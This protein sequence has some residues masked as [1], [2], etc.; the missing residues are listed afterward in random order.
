MK[1]F[2]V[3]LVALFLSITAFSQEYKNSI[4]VKLGY[5]MS[6]DY[7]HNLSESNFINT[8]TSFLFWGAFGLRAYGFYNWNFPIRSVDGLSWYVGPGAYVGFFMNSQYLGFDG[9]INA[10]IGLEYKLRNI[11]LA[12]SFDWAPGLRIT[13]YLPHYVG[14]AYGCGGLGIKYTF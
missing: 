10:M 2:L 13:T 11:P 5:D 3:V 1:K 7:K 12:F 4:G 8:G 14:F 6:I 9:S